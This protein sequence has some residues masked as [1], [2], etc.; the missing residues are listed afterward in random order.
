GALSEPAPANPAWKTLPSWYVAGTQDHSIALET[1]LFMA[2]RA[3]STLT[4]V[5]A[6]H[7]AM[8]AEATAVADVIKTAATTTR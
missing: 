7:L 6:G 3:G 1:Q 8:V 5:D 2:E 4:Q